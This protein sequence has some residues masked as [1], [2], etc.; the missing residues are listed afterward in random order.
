MHFETTNSNLTAIYTVDTSIDA[1]T[2]L[3]LNTQYWYPDGYQYKI[4]IDGEDPP[5]G[6]YH[7]NV[8][9]Y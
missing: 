2:V 5:E 3:Y 7:L 9:D 8:E 6:S 1:P 4:T